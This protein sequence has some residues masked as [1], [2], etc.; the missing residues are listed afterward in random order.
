MSFILPFIFFTLSAIAQ[1]ECR[2]TNKHGW[3]PFNTL[4]SKFLGL[5]GKGLIDKDQ[6][7]D[8]VKR[9][10]KHGACNWNGS[11]WAGYDL[12]GSSVGPETHKS[13][14][15]C[16]DAVRSTTGHLSC[17][18]NGE[19]WQP[20]ST[21]YGGY[22]GRP[23][24]GHDDL[25]DCEDSLKISPKYICNWDGKNFSAYST[26][27]NNAI[28]AFQF[29]TIEDCHDFVGKF[30][31]LDLDRILGHEELLQYSDS[32]PSPIGYTLKGCE[33][34]K[35]FFHHIKPNANDTMQ[36]RCMPDTVY[37]WGDYRKLKFFLENFNNLKD[38]DDDLEKEIFASAS[39]M[40]TF[41]Y[42]P[43]LLRFK[44]KPN[45]RY[46]VRTHTQ[47]AA[48]CSDLSS[49]QRKDT[50][51]ITNWAHGKKSGLDYEI[52]SMEIVDSWSFGSE[53]TYREILREY[54]WVESH[55]PEEYELYYKKNGID[56]IWYENLDNHDFSKNAFFATLQFLRSIAEKQNLGGIFARDLEAVRA[57]FKTDR[58][59]YF[60]ER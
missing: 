41:G 47:K 16:E 32:E 23:T 20:F 30:S 7:D 1:V 48:A 45:L 14:K 46:L 12:Q 53:E 9:T 58:P 49:K 6:C 37:S 24:Y 57:H 60:N 51:I 25:D 5:P 18:W 36:K 44:L 29:K 8:S 26:K 42:G 56:K 10:R 55:G 17:S 27:S 22:I 39:P 19:N 35:N 4:S 15:H 59:I 52:C 3:A 43:V 28:A 54:K 34:E 33:D 21:I 31:A 13:L 38:W 11:G 50:L 40:A 2:E